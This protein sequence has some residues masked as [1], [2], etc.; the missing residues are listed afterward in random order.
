MTSVRRRSAAGSSSL[1]VLFPLPSA[2]CA[3]APGHEVLLRHSSDRHPGYLLFPPGT[4]TVPLP[5]GM[6][7]CLQI[8]LRCISC[9]TKMEWY[10]PVSWKTSPGNV[11]AERRSSHSDLWERTWGLPSCSRS[12][13]D[14]AHPHLLSEFHR[15]RCSPET[16]LHGS[17]RSTHMVP[18][19]MVPVLSRQRVSTLASVSIQYSSCTRVFLFAR[20]SA[21]SVSATLVR[22]ISPSG[23][24]PRTPATMLTIESLKVFPTT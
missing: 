14:L 6:F 5:S 20:T 7:R 12:R 19:V 24:I 17:T 9:R 2:C 16:S 22:R 13:E 21:P 4:G 11:Y 18:S 10:V 15:Y 3:P 1:E 8:R 23:I